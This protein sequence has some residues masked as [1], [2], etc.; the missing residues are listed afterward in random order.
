M[1]NVQKRDLSS[2][3]RRN[4]SF[5]EQEF[6]FQWVREEASVVRYESESVALSVFYEPRSFEVG[7]A[8]ALLDQSRRH[9]TGYSLN[10]LIRLADQIAGQQ[11]RG[12]KA[13]TQNE[14]EDATR[15]LA[16][17]L[18]KYGNDALRGKVAVFDAL[19]AI[20]DSDAEQRRVRAVRSK[21][22]S[23]FSAK[24]YA[25]AVKLYDSIDGHRTAAEEKK[26]AL[27]RRQS[28]Q[29]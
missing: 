18:R 29:M 1:M 26:L 19:D 9:H 2:A 28:Q 22:E 21:A 13:K 20:S 4:F 5:L 14:L 25:E 11:Y 15:S 6:G 12:P 16:G 23:A 8:I 17:Q 10:Y 3:V 7:I 27:A 24:Q